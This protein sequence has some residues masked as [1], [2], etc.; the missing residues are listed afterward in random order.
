MITVVGAPSSGTRLVTRLLGAAGLAVTHDRSHGLEPADGYIV[1]VTRDEQC[2]QASITERWPDGL[3]RGRRRARGPLEDIPLTAFPTPRQ[4]AEIY[5]DAYP[6]SY[7]QL[8][9][10]PDTV[11]STIAD[12]FGITPWAFGENIYDGNARRR[13]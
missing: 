13:Q 6:V 4:L 9:T 10:D 8:V 2:R 1:L 12:D 5:P 7:D 11:I 3:I